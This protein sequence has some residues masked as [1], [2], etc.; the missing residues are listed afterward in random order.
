MGYS[1]EG[2]RQGAVKGCGKCNILP[3]A[4]GELCIPCDKR[5]RN[6]PVSAPGIREL[7]VDG[8]TFKLCAFL[9]LRRSCGR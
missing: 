9:K 7:R 4:A 2:V 5:A 6:A 1:R 3:R 8:R